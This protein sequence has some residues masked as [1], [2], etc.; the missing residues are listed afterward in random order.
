MQDLN[1]VKGYSAL[2]PL[3]N[4]IL[5]NLPDGF[6][7]HVSNGMINYVVPLSIYPQGYHAKKGEPLPFI[8]LAS[9]KNHIALY[10]MGL[11]DN[12]EVEKWFVA[13]Y[14][15]RVST[16]LDMGKSCIRFK[17][18][19]TIPYELIAELCQKITVDD[20]IRFYESSVRLTEKTP[21]VLLKQVLSS[22][23]D[24]I[25][26]KGL[27]GKYLGCNPAYEKLLGKSEAEIVGKTAYDFNDLKLA[28]IF[29]ASDKKVI[30]AKKPIT[31]EVWLD[32]A[33]GTRILFEST[34]SPLF[35]SRGNVFG[36]LGVLRDITSQREAE[37]ALKASE[38][39]Y[40]LITEN[41]SDVI[42]RYNL[43]QDRFTFCS[44]SILQ[45]RGI[46]VEEAMIEKFPDTVMPEFREMM[47]R[48]VLEAKNF[49]IDHPDTT[50]SEILEIRQTTRSGKIIWVE[51]SSKL[52]LNA[53]KELEILGVSRN[54]D[55]RKKAENE[56]LYLGYH[57]QLTGLYN[58]HYFE[59]I[60]PDEM[61][62][63]D[64][65]GEPLSLLLLD[66]DHFKAVNDTWGHPVGDELLQQTANTIGNNIRAADILVRFGGEEFV[67]LMP[68][69]TKDGV[70]EAAEKIRVAISK[71]NHP[72]AGIRTVSIGVAQRMNNESFRHWYRRVD[73]ALYQ[74]KEG[75][76]N[77]VVASDEKI[78]LSL[79]TVHMKWLTSWECGNSEIDRQHRELIEIANRL[80]NMSFTGLSKQETEAQ[81]ELLMKNIL[82]H[83]ESEEK[84]LAA[85]GYPDYP[86]HAK[87]HKRLIAKALRIK[88]SCRTGGVKPSAFFSFIIDDVIL[89]HLRDD[90]VKFFPYTREHSS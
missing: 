86:A 52:S 31:I 48:K 73:E 39:K 61:E 81:I 45:L 13:E 21:S 67:V 42:W 74:A 63:S 59:M 76:R 34:K 66:L 9:Q 7:E 23:T 20:Y 25:F 72:V 11:Y 6:L 56:I 58:R 3:R 27:D 4:V 18:P 62:R 28:E 16:K 84:Y 87:L 85:I 65:Y 79:E 15:R 24:L 29:A 43:D 51:I 50:L 60:I 44:P 53:Q 22:M 8:S 37:E 33:D 49:L 41:T 46:S 35:D 38:N 78:S 71:E 2:L 12:Q 82:E 26:F 32:Q 64:R 19:D 36:I 47:A 55:D 30:T 88:E 90:D 57:D 77:R 70:F 40:R 10:H 83:F 54:I 89:G 14:A 80:V 68:Q 69:T 1:T 75:G 17:N 5:A